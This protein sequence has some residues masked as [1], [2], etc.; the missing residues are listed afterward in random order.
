LLSVTLKRLI[1]WGCN[2]GVH[3]LNS[4]FLLTTF[5]S[6]GT[7]RAFFKHRCASYLLVK[8][9]YCTVMLVAFIC[10]KLNVSFKMGKLCIYSGPCDLFENAYVLWIMSQNYWPV[11]SMVKPSILLIITLNFKEMSCGSLW[12]QYGITDIAEMKD[13]N[14]IHYAY[15]SPF[16][17]KNIISGSRQYTQKTGICKYWMLQLDIAVGRERCFVNF[18]QRSLT[19]TPGRRT[20]FVF[21][22]LFVLML[23]GKKRSSYGVLCMFTCGL[24]PPSW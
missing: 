24:P 10:N 7:A 2:E 19:F 9:W 17:S 14:V 22:V 3:T 16:S 6:V 12:I 13:P 1:I 8:C 18:W 4:D 20:K 11:K 5:K 15:F 23:S 21:F